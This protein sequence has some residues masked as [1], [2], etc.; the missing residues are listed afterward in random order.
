MGVL[1][2]KGKLLPRTWRW[3]GWG[4]SRL[5]CSALGTWQVGLD[6]VTERTL[7]VVHS[8]FL[9]LRPY[10]FVSVFSLVACIYSLNG[11]LFDNNA[12]GRIWPNL[13]MTVFL[14]VRY[15]SLAL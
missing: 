6:D 13:F 10:Y 3:N 12:K 7:C 8:H 2:C 5:G 11:K 4:I 1:P 9:S 15:A 14:C